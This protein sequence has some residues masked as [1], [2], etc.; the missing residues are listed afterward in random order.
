MMKALR[1]LGCSVQL[2][3]ATGA[4][5]LQIDDA[6]AFLPWGKAYRHGFEMGEQE[7]REVLGG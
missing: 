7:T 4:A 3:G 2:D 6:T 5:S 1:Q